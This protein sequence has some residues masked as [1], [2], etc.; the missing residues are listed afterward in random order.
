MWLRDA[1]LG[2][3]ADIDVETGTWS[4]YL[5][6]IERW[7]LPPGILAGVDERAFHVRVAR[8]GGAV[9][10]ASLAFDHEGDCG[11]FNVATMEDAR[12][13]GYGTAVTAAQLRDA[14]ARGCATATLQST[15]VAERL[16][17]SLGFRDLG[18]IHEYRKIAKV[19]PADTIADMATAA[20]QAMPER[21]RPSAASSE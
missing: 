19:P 2:G 8:R 1:A 11:L 14:I 6:F 5:G 7:A 16:Y 3:V 4:D 15:Q 9:V 13:S 20:A 12:R 21:P 10:A 17:A 18:R